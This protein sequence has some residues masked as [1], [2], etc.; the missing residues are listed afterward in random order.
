MLSNNIWIL[1]GHDMDSIDESKNK[2]SAL[3]INAL[4]SYD[5]SYFKKETVVFSF[6]VDCYWRGILDPGNQIG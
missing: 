6:I 5:N 1:Y 3:T 2:V 4:I